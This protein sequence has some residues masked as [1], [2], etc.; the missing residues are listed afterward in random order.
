M[1]EEL[2]NNH[3]SPLTPPS[4]GSGLNFTLGQKVNN[5]KT[6][7]PIKAEILGSISSSWSANSGLNSHHHHPHQPHP[8][9]P[10]NQGLVYSGSGNYGSSHT[11]RTHADK[12]LVP[13]GNG[14]PNSGVLLPP[15]VM[16]LVAPQSSGGWRDHSMG[17]NGPGSAGLAGLGSLTPTSPGDHHHDSHMN[18]GSN[19]LSSSLGPGTQAPQ[20]TSSASSA[21]SPNSAT[22]KAEN[23]E[24]VVCGDKSSGKHYGQFTCEGK[25]SYIHIHYNSIFY[26]LSH[27]SH[28]HCK[29]QLLMYEKIRVCSLSVYKGFGV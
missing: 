10:H 13:P 12:L 2:N 22:V 16:A 18:G 3:S 21:A 4:D 19:G 6:P 5:V 11:T 17:P 29:L 26:L 7:I 27:V 15:D 14:L 28:S 25:K 23:I 20:P 1:K 8:H 9:H 24:C